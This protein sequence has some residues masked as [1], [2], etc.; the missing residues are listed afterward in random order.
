MADWF[1]RDAFWARFREVMFPPERWEKTPEAVDALLSRL[2]L[3]PGSRLLD[4]CCGPG[5]HSLELARR[6]YRVTAVDRTAA[7]L[8]EGR[9]R[10]A[11]ERLEIEWVCEDMRRFA[12]PGA[13]DGAINLFTSFGYFEDPADDLRVVRNL[14][15]SLRPGGRLVMDL[16]GKERIARIFSERDWHWVDRERG[17]LMLEERRLSPGWGWIETTWTLIGETERH[18][19]TFGHRLYAGTELAGLLR[20]AGF[21]SVDLHG[22]VDGSPYD[23][24][25]TRLVAVACR[26][27]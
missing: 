3:P 4:L 20:Q 10:A 11:A 6:G 21:G 25:A 22:G 12:R 23:Q 17:L 5:R 19:E 24:A 13:F 7:Y 18:A 1:E 15:E 27:A 2:D 26:P 9:N 14:C 16:M 8:D